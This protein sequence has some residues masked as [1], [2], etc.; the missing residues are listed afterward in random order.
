MCVITE[1]II[2]QNVNLPVAF[3]VVQMHP[4][5]FYFFSHILYLLFSVCPY[6]YERYDGLLG[7][8]SSLVGFEC[9]AAGMMTCAG[10]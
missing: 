7:N 5:Y 6:S 3:A 1:F 4:I 9:T 2:P 10:A 8:C